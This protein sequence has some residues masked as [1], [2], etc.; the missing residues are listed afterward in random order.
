MPAPKPSKIHPLPEATRRD[1]LKVFSGGAGALAL[2]AC[3]V[4]PGTTLDGGTGGGTGTGGGNTGAGGGTAAGGGASAGGGTGSNPTCQEIA[5]ETLGPYP[6]KVGMLNNAMYERSD[7]AEG[8]AGTA[9]DVVL[10]LVNTNAA[11]AAITGAKVVVWHCDADGHYSE[12]AGQPGYDGTGTTY[13]R[14][15]QVSD[16]NGQV[17]FKTVYPG[18]YPGRATHIHIEVFVNGTSRKVTQLAF[19]ET[20]NTAVYAQGVYASKGS[21]PQ[22]NGNDMVF[23]D[24][25]ADELATVTGNAAT[26]YLA[27]LTIGVDL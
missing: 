15:V 22:T 5:S 8:K 4:A 19:P 24:S 20:V 21:N 13:M 6:D 10:S 23:Q 16:N 3:G 1:A 26:G 12:Y 2:I 14:G 11:C 25:L 18:W 9:L 27:A 17:T 7:I